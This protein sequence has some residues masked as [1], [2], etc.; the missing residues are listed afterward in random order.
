MFIIINSLQR[1]FINNNFDIV[2][3][4]SKILS[5]RG[6]SISMKTSLEI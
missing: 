3:V 2:S 5:R 1:Y 4:R 6:A